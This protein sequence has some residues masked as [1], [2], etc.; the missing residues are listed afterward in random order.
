[1]TDDVNF[2][3]EITGIKATMQE[4]CIGFYLWQNW[5]LFMFE[6]IA[7]FEYQLQSL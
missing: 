1:M 6:I 3:E 4:K 7:R 2:A 5:L